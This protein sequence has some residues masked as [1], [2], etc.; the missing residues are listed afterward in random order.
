MIDLREHR[1]E[2]FTR[3]RLALELR[4]GAR[5]LVTLIVGLALALAAF[6]YIGSNVSKTL[7]RSTQ[8]LRFSIEDATGVVTGV[9][10]VRFKGVPAG[11]MSK[12]DTGGERP[13]LTVKLQKEY[14]DIYRDAHAILRPNTPLQDMYLDI[15]DP[16]TPSAGKADKSTVLPA[17]RTQTSVRV[18]EVLNVF[19]PEVR[20][21]LRELLDG[22]GN[23]TRDNGAALRE[24]FVELVPFLRTAGNITEQLARREPLTRRLVHNTAVLTSELGRRDQ[25]I[26]RLVNDMGTTLKTV[27]AGAGDLDATLRALPPTLTSIDSSFAAVRGVLGDVNA[28]VQSLYPVADRLPVSLR[29]LRRLGAEAQPALHALQRPVARLVPFAQALSPLSKNLGISA[30]TLRPQIPSIDKVSK[31]LAGCR[32]GIQGFFF[33]DASISKYGDNHGPVPRGNLTVGV[34]TS[35]F[36]EGPFE[37]AVPACTPG[38][39]MG[40]RPATAKDMR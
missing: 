22:L 19:Q 32:R 40:G 4:R 3:D 10:E 13:V 2:H 27:Q 18:D 8:E 15:V 36:N 24:A 5:P 30:T 6:I 31:G 14:G 35:A 7:L 17:E 20:V 37:Q 12:L 39:A 25:Q 38:R 34:G 9:H 1:T 21:R 28:A 29:A 11:T 23:G 16:G 33:W 26:R